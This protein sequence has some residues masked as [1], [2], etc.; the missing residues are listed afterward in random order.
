MPADLELVLVAGDANPD[1]ILTGDVVPRFGQ[2]EQLLDG[3]TLTI[4]S[5]AG[6]TAHAFARLGRPVALV[7]AVGTDHF[8]DRL[9]EQL[10]A[11]GVRTELML[12][13]DDI[14]TGLTVVLS[15]ADDR[16]ILTLPGAI[17]TLTPDEIRAAAARSP[18]LRHVHVSSFFLQPR[19][20][21]DLPML[22]A[23]LQQQG[24]STSMDTNDDPAGRWEGVEA[25]LPHL[26]V[27]LPNRSE[28]QAIAGAPDA[29]EAALALA[30]RGPLVVVKDGPRGAFAVTPSGERLECPGEARTAVDTT[31][32]GDTFDAAF[33]DSWLRGDALTVSLAR[34][35]RAGAL[36]VGAIGGTGGQPTRGVLDRLTDLAP[37]GRTLQ[38]S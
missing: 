13:R 15:T 3:A 17:P 21:G 28:V 34:A 30:A 26:D 4:G 38:G 29:R 7:A 33:L 36:A 19:L 9:R 16:A 20:A 22:L 12:R 23:E 14:P 32:A 35:V 37:A 25:L 8:G 2:L 31:G 24:V 1:L 6:I 5:S 27:L 18:G 10:A 11:A